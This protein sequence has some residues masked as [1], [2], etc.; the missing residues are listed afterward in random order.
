SVACIMRRIKQR[1]RNYETGVKKSYIEYLNRL[2]HKWRN[3]Y[4]L[5]P[6]LDID[7]E[8]I[9]YFSNFID[10]SDILTEINRYCGKE[11]ERIKN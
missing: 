9:D 4:H 2:Y 10:R 1:G 3:R 6:V 5:S 7:T 8:K 11:P